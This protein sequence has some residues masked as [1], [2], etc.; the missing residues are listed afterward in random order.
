MSGQLADWKWCSICGGGFSTRAAFCNN[1]Y[2]WGSDPGRYLRDEERL[3]ACAVG[4]RIPAVSSLS[5]K[6]RTHALPGQRVFTVVESN[7]YESNHF[8]KIDG[9]T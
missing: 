5:P 6:Y 2:L 3:S 9:L 7:G 8:V 4:L 1:G